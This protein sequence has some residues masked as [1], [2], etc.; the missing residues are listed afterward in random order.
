MILKNE[1][2]I[3]IKTMLT[4]FLVVMSVLAYAQSSVTEV[5]TDRQAPSSATDNQQHSFNFP[6]WP[7]QRHVYR[8]RIPLAPPGPY[9]SSAL[10]EISFDR[11]R[12]ENGK[13]DTGKS[14]PLKPPAMHMQRFN[15]GAPWPN[16]ARS[17]DSGYALPPATQPES[18]PNDATTATGDRKLSDG[19]RHDRK[20]PDWPD[21]YESRNNWPEDKRKIDDWPQEWAKKWPHVT[22]HEDEW[23]SNRR[24]DDKWPDDNWS[25]STWPEDKWP[26][27]RRSDNKWPDRQWPDRQWPDHQ[28]ARQSGQPDTVN[29]AH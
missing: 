3:L 25:N 22:R 14:Q 18:G 27:S 20:W 13:G 29:P 1:F 11:S 24:T 5:G 7:E 4:V 12:F 17:R 2:N 10:S 26:D 19:N 9:M 23:A 28:P 15:P 16:N 6:R 21:S 8:D